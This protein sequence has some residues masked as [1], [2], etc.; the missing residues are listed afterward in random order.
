MRYQASSFAFLLLLSAAACGAPPAASDAASPDANSDASMDAAVPP[1]AQPPS[2]ATSLDASPPPEASTDAGS[3]AAREAALHGHVGVHTM[4]LF[5]GND[6]LYL[7]H[8]PAYGD[9]HNM[10]LVL[11]VALR[12]T[13]AGLPTDFS[14]QLYSIQPESLS[15]D[16]L[17]EGTRTRFSA[18]VFQGN[19]EQGGTRLADSVAFEVQG[20]EY[21]HVLASDEPAAPLRYL[22]LTTPSQAFAVH[23][24]GAPPDFDHVLRVDV[25]PAATAPR[26][27]YTSTASNDLAHRLANP[28][29]FTDERGVATT[30]G[31]LTELSCLQGPYFGPACP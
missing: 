28:A 10:Q 2:D 15:L 23:V 9:P 8:L 31:L 12:S 19:L 21:A 26:M 5:G 30:L 18:S 24:L 27:L 22:V 29:P 3:E 7:S 4:L 13:P 6:G 20:V 14:R 11:R 25:R 1:D 17:A 16:E